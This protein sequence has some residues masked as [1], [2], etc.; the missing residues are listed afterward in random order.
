MNFLEELR[1]RADALRERKT[2]DDTALRRHVSQVESACKATLAYFMSLMEHLN[3]LHPASK[4]RF[5]LDRKHAFDGLHLTDFYV[6]SRR[7]RWRKDEVFDLLVL[8][9]QLKS[10]QKMVMSKD[11]LPEIQQLE[12]RLRQGGVTM[13]AETVRNPQNGKLQEMRYSFVADFRGS[14]RIVPQH[15]AG[16]LQ[17][18]LQNLDGL[19]A[20]AFDLPAEDVDGHRLDELA[21]WLVGEPHDFLKGAH[22][23]RRIEA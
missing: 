1:R 2:E 18:H 10:G 9:W 22:N 8:H 15:D 4:A 6:D 21:R 12:D 23:L 5:Q 17:F 19:E 11:F 13:D 3:V 7:K 16:L 20:V 14:V